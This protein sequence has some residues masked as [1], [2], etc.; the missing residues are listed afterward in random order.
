LTGTSGGSEILKVEKRWTVSNLLSLSRV[1]FLFP[2][3]YYILKPGSG[4]RVTVIILMLLAASTDFLDG[5]LARKLN[6]VTDFGRLLDPVTDKISLITI[7]AA[8]V[9]VGD[10]PLWFAALLALRDILIVA[11]GSV[12]IRRRKVVVQSVWAGKWTVTVIAVY[13]IL[14]TLR[15]DSLLP[16]KIFFLY[17]STLALF[18]SLGVYIMIYRKHMAANG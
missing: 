7:S 2:I 15:I 14:A 10:V 16:A 6:Q 18:A 9:L 3:V 8:L 11:G 13:L 12:I 5:F 17:F 4:Y 1:F